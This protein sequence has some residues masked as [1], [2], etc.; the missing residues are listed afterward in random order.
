[1]RP[2]LASERPSNLPRPTP[3]RSF[4]AIV[5]EHRPLLGK[6]ARSEHSAVLDDEGNS[7]EALQSKRR[8]SGHRFS[9]GYGAIDGGNSLS[10]RPSPVQF[11]SLSCNSSEDS[12]T[13]S[14]TPTTPRAL[15]GMVLPAETEGE[16]TPRP[17]HS[18]NRHDFFSDHNY[19]DDEAEDSSL[20]SSLASTHSS[21]RYEAQTPLL[22]SSLPYDPEQVHPHHSAAALS[23]YRQT[24]SS[25][26]NDTIPAA[27]TITPPLPDSTALSDSH[28][29][30]SLVV[31]YE[32]DGAPSHPSE[33]NLGT[34]PKRPRRIY[35]SFPSYSSSY[36]HSHF[37]PSSLS[38]SPSPAPAAA[39]HAVY[40]PHTYPHP[41]RRV[42]G[43]DVDRLQFHYPI[44]WRTSSTLRHLS[45][46]LFFAWAPALFYRGHLQCWCIAVLVL[47]AGKKGVSTWAFFGGVC[48]RSGLMSCSLGLLTVSIGVY[49]A[50]LG[51]WGVLG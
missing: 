38:P 1:V 31:V 40:S 6:R 8:D 42:F 18:E 19:G 14:L 39:P 32:D 36:N 7:G 10:G 17:I 33:P 46:G 12:S 3:A 27:L 34:T 15:A 45:H 16:A 30:R 23:S 28:S 24:S 5:G 22:S 29:E 35:P 41:K 11:P 2:T 21:S 13:T 51:V 26:L 49:F 4:S 25:T 20:S 44:I 47:L 9:A 50:A 48:A 37:P 43:V